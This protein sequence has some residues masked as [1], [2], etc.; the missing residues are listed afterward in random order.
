MDP[1]NHRLRRCHSQLIIFLKK[2]L[3]DKKG[4]EGPAA[5]VKSKLSREL[6]KQAVTTKCRG[7]YQCA[8]SRAFEKAVSIRA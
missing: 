4:N 1:R 5:C 8:A 6:A 3:V 7:V 2:E